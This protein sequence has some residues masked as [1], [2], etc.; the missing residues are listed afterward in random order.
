MVNTGSLCFYL[1][2]AVSISPA[3]M[4]SGWNETEVGPSGSILKSWGN[5][6]FTMFYLSMQ[7]ELFLA[8]EF[9]LVLSNAG[10]VD[11]MLQAK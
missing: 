7:G 3:L 2:L 9:Y 4:I 1:F 8:R 6:L 11:G 5:W 10:L